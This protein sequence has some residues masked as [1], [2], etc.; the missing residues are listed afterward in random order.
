M[1]ID[2]TYEQLRPPPSICVTAAA[3]VVQMIHV[4]TKLNKTGERRLS[5][6]EEDRKAHKRVG[7]GGTHKIKCDMTLVATEPVDAECWNSAR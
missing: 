4:R 5:K 7:E 2:V 3:E 1:V 6:P